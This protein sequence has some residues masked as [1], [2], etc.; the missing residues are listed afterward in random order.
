M[1]IL[2]FYA[3]LALGMLLD[4][5]MLFRLVLLCAAIHECGH[6]AAYICCAKRLPKLSASAGGVCL[7]RTAG[8][9]HA[10]KLIVLCAG[11]AAN[12]LTCFVL[13]AMAQHKASYG[14][15]FFASVSF[16]TAIYNLLPFGALDGAQLVEEV[17]P[18]R[19]LHAWMRAQGALLAA[20]C[21]V[22]PLCAWSLGWPWQARFACVIAPVYLFVQNAL[23]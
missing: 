5:A 3:M 15:Y 2:C 8:L 14:A 11:P 6:V 1:K 23:S 20:F 22:L 4:G 19:H 17:L 16:C 13:Y 21:A 9:S 10:A 18:A 7:S 12:L